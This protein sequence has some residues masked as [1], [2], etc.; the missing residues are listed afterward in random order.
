M[1]YSPNSTEIMPVMGARINSIQIFNIAGKEVNNLLA[2][3]EYRIQVRGVFLDD[4]EAVRFGLHIRTR[5]GLTITGI[6]HPKTGTFFPNVKKGQKYK[7]TYKIK[8]Y[9]APDTYF[10]GAGVWSSKEPVRLH[11]VLDFIM[12][13]V[14][15]KPENRAFGYVNLSESKPELKISE[16]EFSEYYLVVPTAC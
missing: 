11:Q 14:L 2:G 3:R 16:D 5:T 15:P 9:L 10:V 7:L 4:H 12:F 1:N 8:M 6:S 13:R